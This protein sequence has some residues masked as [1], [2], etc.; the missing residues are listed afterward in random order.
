MVLVRHP[1]G[2]PG[3]WVARRDYERLLEFGQVFAPDY[4][5]VPSEYVVVEYDHS[6]LDARPI[7]L[8]DPTHPEKPEGLPYLQRQLDGRGKLPKNN[9][10][11]RPADLLTIP[12]IAKRTSRTEKKIREYARHPAFPAPVLIVDRGSRSNPI[13]YYSYPEVKRWMRSQA[14]S[15]RVKDIAKR[16]T[17]AVRRRTKKGG[18]VPRAQVT[19]AQGTANQRGSRT[20]D[21]GHDHPPDAGSGQS[22]S[23]RGGGSDGRRQEDEQPGAIAGATPAALQ[24]RADEERVEGPAPRQDGDVP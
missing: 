7:G 5:L 19:K 3:V 11:V 15:I 6:T 12:Q 10:L 22:S 18:E 2:G 21:A 13:R 23:P 1:K 9:D 20:P 8:F 4:V 24:G 16:K 17:R 14:L